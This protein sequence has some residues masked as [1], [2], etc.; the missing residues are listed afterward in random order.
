MRLN[1]YLD[2]LEPD[3]GN[4]TDSV[5]LTTESGDKNFVVFL[6]EVEA[7]VVGDEGCD[8]L[9]VLDQLNTN[10][11]ADSRVRLFGLNTDL[12]RQN[13]KVNNGS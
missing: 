13:F 8:L 2:N 10:A 9:S 6:D 3:S 1:W 7:T 11:L 12:K 5:T 4:I